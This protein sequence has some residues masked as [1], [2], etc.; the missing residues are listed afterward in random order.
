MIEHLPRDWRAATLLGR[1]ETLDGPTPV[2]VRKGR[3]LDVSRLAPTTSE[4]SYEL[5]SS[6]GVDLGRGLRIQPGLE[7]WAPCIAP[8]VSPVGSPLHQRGRAV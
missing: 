8:P 1:L 5:A 2:V 3:L 4:F 6:G 7:H